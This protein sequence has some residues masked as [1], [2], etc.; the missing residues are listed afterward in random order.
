MNDPAGNLR[1][2]SGPARRRGGCG[3]NIAILAAAVVA[4]ALFS[5]G[6]DLFWR[7]FDERRYRW[8]FPRPGRQVLAT[9][10]TGTLVTGGG[11][12]RDA[13][14]EFRYVP[15]PTGRGRRR[16]RSGVSRRGIRLA[17]TFVLCGDGRD[18]R[19]TVSGNSTDRSGARVDLSLY[20]ADSTPPDGLAAS[21]LHLFWEG[22]DSLRIEADVYR[23]EGKSAI[24]STDDLDTGRPAEIT[25]QRRTAPGVEAGCK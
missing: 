13:Y 18:K 15:R 19:F 8:A 2:A 10:W 11:Q 3:R 4:I 21:H 25:M 17:G 1:N 22:G 24:T 9:E 16:S 20:P 14:L 5:A 6:M 7:R 23:R 12:R